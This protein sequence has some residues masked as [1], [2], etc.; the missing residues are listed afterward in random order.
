MDEQG[1]AFLVATAFQVGDSLLNFCDSN[2]SADR[3]FANFADDV[4]AFASAWSIIQPEL[5]DPSIALSPSLLRILRLISNDG[6]VILTRLRESITTLNSRYRKI[7]TAATKDFILRIRSHHKTQRHQ[8]LVA[9]LGQQLVVLH[10]SQII[11]ATSTL[12]VILVVIQ[13]VQSTYTLSLLCLIPLQSRQ[14][15][16]YTTAREPP[17]L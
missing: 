7:G 8:L 16:T 11:F 5:R 12:N 17:Y 2:T 9:F 10:R 1:I 6:T 3:E 4:K 13:W 15:K 14:S